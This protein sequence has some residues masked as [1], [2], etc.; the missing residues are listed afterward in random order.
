MNLRY[1]LISLVTLAACSAE[2]KRDFPNSE[3]KNYSFIQL[4]EIP[5]VE[6]EDLTLK[7]SGSVKIGVDSLTHNPLIYPFYFDSGQHQYFTHFNQAINS[8]DIYDMGLGKLIKRISY[9]TAGLTAISNKSYP[10]IKSLDSI[11]VWT[12]DPQMVF[13]TD[14][15]GQKKTEYVFAGNGS[16]VGVNMVQHFYVVN[17]KAI[18]A[19][20][21]LYYDPK[22]R[23]TS[24]FLLF[25]LGSGKIQK[26]AAVRP[27]STT[28]FP[29]HR[30]NAFPRLCLGHNNSI[31]NYF[32]AGPLIMQT[33]LNSGSV[34]YFLLRSKY[35]E[36]PYP[37]PPNDGN[38]PTVE[39]EF[40]KGGYFLMEYD[41]YRHVYYL[42]CL[43]DEK[44][45][46]DDLGN[47]KTPDDMQL[48]IVISDTLFRYRG[49]ILLP[50]NKFFRS[51]LVTKEGLLVSDAHPN[52]PEYPDD[53]LSYTLFKV[54]ATHD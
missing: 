15:S 43:L 13:M 45:P 20:N 52:N 23:D 50:K 17:N 29:L 8:L 54:F 39:N 53:S 40:L 28:S 18:L 33:S 48:S 12:Y 41:R 2:N 27:I 42:M 31:I 22:L 34:K 24:N 14:S 10:F 9:P 1:L 21:P 46:L 32:G 49:E 38:Q 3:L 6:L 37:E 51:M 4:A 30:S 26:S 16:D 36:E 5:Q 35:Q 44:E 11:Y 19:Y 7:E 25:D 47:V